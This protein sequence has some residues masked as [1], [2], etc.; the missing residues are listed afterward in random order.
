[1]KRISFHALLVTVA[2]AAFVATIAWPAAALLGQ[3]VLDAPE[4]P[5]PRAFSPRLL[6]LL[7]RSTWLAASAVFACIALAIP[8]IYA[9]GR[10]H[11]AHA[12]SLTAMFAAMLF[13]PPMVYVF[14]WDRAVPALIEP[15]G[16]CILIWAF[17]AWPIPTLIIGR[18][19]ARQRH[20]FHDAALLDA[21]PAQAFLRIA[22]P[23]L[24]A[25]VV[26]AAMLLFVLF[27][28]DYGVPHACGLTVAAT[29]LLGRATSSR[30]PID[31][32]VPSLPSVG[33]TVA[34]L[35]LAAWLWR[36]SVSDDGAAPATTRP[37]NMSVRVLVLPILLFLV[38]WAVPVVAL[39]LKMTPDDINNALRTYAFDVAASIG[40]AACAGVIVF[41]IA[42]GTW[43]TPTLRRIMLAWSVVWGI[44]PGAL[45][46]ESLVAGYNNALLMPVYAHGTILVLGYVARFAWVGLA[47]ATALHGRADAAM[48]DQVAVDGA[49]PGQRL[50]Y[51]ILPVHG[52]LL[53]AASGLGTVLAVA[54]LPVS[55]MIRPPGL[56]PVSLII[57]EK[58]HRF[59][60]GLLIALSLTLVGLALVVTAVWTFSAHR[61]RS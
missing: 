32:L 28:N 16:R 2:V 26:L 19:L 33:V 14:G 34:A 3:C 9:L 11:A 36:S 18:A 13:C 56:T 8:A 15:H 47:L 46:G 4:A 31:T 10:L 42:L 38:T 52:P 53:A 29:D 5:P 39:C 7:V 6:G 43:Q 61:I 23:N 35:A 21:S 58:F 44:V 12:R 55:T 37:S 57:V 49:S 59:E 40:L 48:L 17:W 22:L 20:A 25:P 24:R 50:R 54:E 45:V 60:D 30:H 27:F 1:V 41:A 51:V